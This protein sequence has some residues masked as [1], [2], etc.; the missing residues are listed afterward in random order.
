MT[1]S[2][3]ISCHA[4]VTDLMLQSTIKPVG[5]NHHGKE[6]TPRDMGFSP[7]AAKHVAE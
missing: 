5:V 4:I 6:K 3:I 7:G 1:S 2:T